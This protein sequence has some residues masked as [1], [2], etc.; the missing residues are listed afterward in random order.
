MLLS[1]QPLLTGETLKGKL[2]FLAKDTGRG[3][4]REFKGWILL[5][6]HDCQNNPL[7]MNEL[8][9]KPES[10]SFRRS[11]PSWWVTEHWS[12]SHFHGALQA[13]G[14]E[15]LEGCTL[16]Y[17]LFI[18]LFFVGVSN[19]ARARWV[20]KWCIKGYRDWSLTSSEKAW[21]AFAP[22][23]GGGTGG[24]Q[25][26]CSSSASALWVKAL[27]SNNFRT[28]LAVEVHRAHLIYTNVEDLAHCSCQSGWH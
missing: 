22:I 3:A 26:F 15:G 7:G 9:A 20:F 4:G 25:T 27:K 28:S 19:H 2:S 5:Q 18:A 21:A 24:I 13:A 23:W 6:F 16:L 12:C 14:L 8:K 10:C 17:P 1:G 11:K